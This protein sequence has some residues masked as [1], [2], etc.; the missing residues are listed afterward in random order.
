MNGCQRVIYTERRSGFGQHFDIGTKVKTAIAREP[1][2]DVSNE[3]DTVILSNVHTLNVDRSLSPHYPLTLSGV[4]Q[5]WIGR[6]H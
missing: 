1:R 4:F 6:P 3:S 2:T 5:L